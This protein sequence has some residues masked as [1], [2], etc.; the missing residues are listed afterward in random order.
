MYNQLHNNGYNGTVIIDAEDTDIYVQA[1]YVARTLDGQLLMKRKKSYVDCNSFLRGDIS[2]VI[3][4]LHVMTGCDQNCGFYGRGEKAVMEKVING[5]EARNLL[6]LCGETLSLQPNVLNSLRKV[7]LKYIYGSNETSCNSLRKVLLK[8]I[9]GSNETSCNSLRKVLLKYIYGSNETSCN[10]LRKVLLKYIY[11]SNE[12]SCN[13]LRKVLLKYIYGSNETSCNSLR[14]VLLKY[15]YGINETSCNS[16]RKV[17]LKYIY[18]SNE[19]SCN[20]LRKVLL[21]FIYMGATKP[22]VRMQGLCN[23]KI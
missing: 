23:G 4:Q 7:L 8:Y 21:K 6:S 22:L 13:S 10:S 14:K 20:S 9:Y 11:G 15:I 5:S 3:I 16:L 19:T 2:D 12:T 17:L 1:A 18:G